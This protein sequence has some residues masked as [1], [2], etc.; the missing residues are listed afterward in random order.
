[1]I[2]YQWKIFGKKRTECHVD[3]FIHMFILQINAF[4]GKTT[5]QIKSFLNKKRKDDNARDNER[6][7]S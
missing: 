5:N 4:S 1:M 7:E 3:A 6:Y 2:V